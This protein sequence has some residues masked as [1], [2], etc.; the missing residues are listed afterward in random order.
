MKQKN[1]FTPSINKFSFRNY[2]IVRGADFT[3]H[4]RGDIYYAEE[5]I[6]YYD[7]LY[8]NINNIESVVFIRIEEP[9]TFL[10]EKY[11]KYIS[12]FAKNLLSTKE[13]QSGLQELLKD[14]EFI[15]YLYSFMHNLKQDNNFEDKRLVGLI[16][17]EFMQVISLKDMSINLSDNKA[18]IEYYDNNIALKGGRLLDHNYPICLFRNLEDFIIN[19][20]MLIS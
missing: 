15:T 3:N 10:E 14:L 5:C 7:P 13:N 20:I 16:N 18:V 17:N 2:K 6:G 12:L 1:E 11:S 9:Y 8:H 19:N 4:V